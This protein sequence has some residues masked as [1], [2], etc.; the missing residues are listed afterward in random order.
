MRLFLTYLILSLLIE[1][2]SFSQLRLPSIIGSGMVLEQNDSVNIWGW[3]FTGQKITVTPS[4]DARPFVTTVSN[5]GRWL[6]RLKT[7]GYGGPHTIDINAPGK[8]IMLSD[9]LIGE[10]WL[11][12]GQSNMEYSYNSGARF[13]KEE[14][15]NCYNNNIRFYQI[16]RAA[17]DF[18]QDDIKAEW[19]TCDSN[20]LKS[21][22][23]VGYFFG[24]KL[25]QVLNIPIGLINASWG[26][27]PAE[28]WTP[29]EFISANE[30]LKTAAGMLKEVP[31]GPV[32]PGLN[33]NGMI[34]PITRF[35]IAGVIWYQ[36]EANT[37]GHRT[38]AQ[39]LTTMIDSWRTRWDREFPFYYVQIAPFK[40][41][42]NNTGALLQEQQTKVMSHPKTGMVVT[43][44]LIDSITNIHPSDKR[45][46]GSRLAGWALAETYHQNT[47]PYKSPTYKDSRLEKNKL[48]LSFNDAPGGFIIKGKTIQ[49]FFISGDKE[50][51]QPAEARIE[52]DK[53]I[54]WNKDLKQPAFVRYG[55]GDTVIGNLFSKEGLPLCPFRTDN[56]EAD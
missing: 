35:D 55:F 54:V 10:V 7:P 42:G 56:W 3:G 32:K 12:S 37:G 52:N 38:Y 29:A 43:T 48:W 18:P 27:T 25:Q 40:Y 17:S 14:L 13:I 44:D 36:G 23:A 46:V 26:G 41:G 31:W 33:F 22:S 39:L 9:V 6:V 5:L 19:K 49:G 53:I 15:P 30:T 4:W 1:I 47:G 24:K 45:Y 51:W 21:F 28:A 50:N 11:C 34:A 8:D 2:P 16:P 20:S